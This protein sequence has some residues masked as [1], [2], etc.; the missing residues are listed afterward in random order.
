MDPSPVLDIVKNTFTEAKSSKFTNGKNRSVQI[1]H[2]VFPLIKEAGG[3]AHAVISIDPV[4]QE[5]LP[6]RKWPICRI[7]LHVREDNEKA[8]A[9]R[10][11]SIGPLHHKRPGLEFM[12]AQKL[13]LFDSLLERGRHHGIYV[14]N[15]LS[16]A[17]KELEAET[18]ECYAEDLTHI[19]SD[20]FTKMMLVDGCFVI[21]LLRLGGKSYQGKLADDPIFATRWMPSNLGLDLLL[22]EN[23]LPLF[24]LQRLFDLTR[25]GDEKDSLNKLAL[26]FFES[27]RP[28]KDAIT[29]ETT[30][31]ADRKYTHLLA[32]FH[33]SFAPTETYCSNTQ[34]RRSCT[35]NTYSGKGWIYSAK[36]LSL[37]GLTFKKKSGNMLD[38]E[39]EDGV[40]KISQLFIDDN[41]GIVLRNLMAHEQGDRGS[42]PYFTSLVVFLG[43][44]LCSR[45][46]ARVLMKAGIIRQP[47][48]D[49]EEVVNFFNSLVK[50][51]VFDMD[52][53]Y[54]H[55]L[56]EDV[57][58]SS[59][60]VWAKL[61]LRCRPILPHLRIIEIAL[62]T[63]SLAQTFILIRSS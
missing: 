6:C 46:D 31:H 26:Q 18:R 44:L 33:A 19:D 8:Y 28:G 16:D 58:I 25:L 9:P 60:S 62:F 49:E 10:L 52:R 53:C 4:R 34:A 3:K 5:P 35:Y 48:N 24:V 13:R 20:S 45:D 12:Q 27:L 50:Q 29:S 54:L 21:E 22:I 55:E 59:Q 2:S 36:S 15:V 1:T 37:C 30:D 14:L 17:M 7:P 38:L 51:L 11:V 56:I 47:E 32:L 42:A 23:Q 40:L 57:N 63:V 41:T 61:R 43:N 39:F